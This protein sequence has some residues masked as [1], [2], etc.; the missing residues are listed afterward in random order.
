MRAL[1]SKRVIA[2]VL[3]ASI[4]GAA[5]GA[6][7]S[8]VLSQQVIADTGNVHIKVIRTAVDGNYDSGWHVHTGVAIV[9]VQSGALQITQNGCTPTTVGPGQTFIE[10]PFLVVRGVATGPTS[11]TT[12]QITEGFDPP[13]IPASTYTGQT[14]FNPCPS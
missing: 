10:V 12:T 9:Q 5:T 4:G 1:R 11:W 7:I 3:A 13:Q 2:L 14:N 8:A 6:A